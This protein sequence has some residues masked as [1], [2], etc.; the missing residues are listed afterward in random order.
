L[1]S[2]RLDPYGLDAFAE[3]NRM[4]A[5]PALVV[6]GDSRAAQWQ[7]PRTFANVAN[8]GIGSQTTVQVLG[9]LP[10]D[11]LALRPRVVLLQVGVNDLKAIPL[12]PG[13]ADA[14][15]ARCKRNIE[16]IVRTLAANQIRVAATTIF[17]LG[18]VPPERRPFWSPDMARAIADV[19]GCIATLADESTTVFDTGPVLRDERGAV[20]PRYGRDLLHLTPEGYAALN[21]E[22]AKHLA[23]QSLGTPGRKLRPTVRTGE[24]HERRSRCAQANR[25]NPAEDGADDAGRPEAVRHC[26]PG[27]APLSNRAGPGLRSRPSARPRQ[28]E[29]SPLA[30]VLLARIS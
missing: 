29:S 4:A 17:P 22:V 25:R 19:N 27:A 23:E 18:A 10:L 15:R 21:A 26:H 28:K 7:L 30:A 2:V 8:R 20:R 9:R 11:V 6:C 1:N 16:R 13:R 24:N 5:S 3:S 14:I 12:F